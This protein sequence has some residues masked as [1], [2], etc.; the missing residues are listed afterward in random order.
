VKGPWRED[1]LAGEPEGSVEK[2]LETGIFFIGAPFGEP[3]GGPVYQG[4]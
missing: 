4:L 3:G 2:A 1:S